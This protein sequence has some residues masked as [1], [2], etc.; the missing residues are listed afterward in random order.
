MV[1]WLNSRIGARRSV[2]L[3]TIKWH[4]IPKSMECT[5]FFSNGSGDF[6]TEQNGHGML[7]LDGLHALSKTC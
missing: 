5:A 4:V 3:T 1:V 6:S 7:Q 2:T